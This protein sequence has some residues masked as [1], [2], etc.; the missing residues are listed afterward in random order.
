MTATAFFLILFSAG[1][2][3]SW[4][5]LAKKSH[6]TFAFYTA[7]MIVDMLMGAWVLFVLPVRLGSLSPAFYLT[8]CG[9]ALG[10][11]IYCTGLVMSYRRM[12]MSAAYP[13]MR[14]LPLIFTAL[15]TSVFGVGKPLSLLALIGMAT[16]FAGCVVM[17]LDKF[18]DFRLSNYRNRTILFVLLAALGT[19]LYTICDSEAQKVMGVCTSKVSAAGVAA[20]VGMN[21]R[22]P[23]VS[24][25]MISCTYYEFRHIAVVAALGLVVLVAVPSARAEATAMPRNGM[26]TPLL[27]GVFAGLTYILVLLAMNHVT[28]VS[29]VQG[30]RQLG[31]VIGMLEGI[32]ILKERCTLTRMTGITLI[33]SGLVLTVIDPA[34]VSGW[35]R[36]VCDRI[37]V[38]V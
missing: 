30:F 29:Y 8:T 23:M 5:L 34:A 35:F 32:F 6:M 21:A 11:T 1:L 14:S 31:L 16:V 33:V 4:N 12:D 7:M 10:E 36:F 17:P 13:M 9:A 18:S 3:A 27:A 26:W 19:T 28:N 37:A 22:I 15:V 24:D 25:T 20:V 38:M 2:H